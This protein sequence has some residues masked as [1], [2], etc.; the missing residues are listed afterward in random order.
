MGELTDRLVQ[1][2]SDFSPARVGE[3]VRGRS[4]A[5]LLDLFGAMMAASAPRYGA[6]HILRSFI[7]QQGGKP[8]AS[9]VGQR[10][11]TSTVNAALANGILGYYCDIEPHHTEAVLHPM[12]VVVP[13]ALA[14]GEF[15]RSSGGDLLAAV[16]LGVE[17]ACRIALALDPRALYSRGFHPTAVA[18]VF[19]ATAAA[20]WL[21]QLE[22]R[23]WQSAIGLAGLQAGGLLAWADDDTELSR[24]FNPGI[25]SRA[26]VTAATMAGLGLGGPWSVLEG[27]SDIFHAFSGVR[28]PNALLA[29]FGPHYAIEEL[30]TKLYACCAFLHPGLDALLATMKLEKLTIVDIASMDFHFSRTG[31]PIV[32][33]NR[34]RS[35]NAQYV[36]AVAA[37]KQTVMIDDILSDQRA[38]PQIAA[39][40]GRVRVIHDPD[41]DRDYPHVY[42]TRLIIRLHDG[43]E[44]SNRV[45]FPKG[46][47]RNPIAPEELIAKYRNLAV[48][49]FSKEAAGRLLDIVADVE[50]L[51]DVSELG[52][53]LRAP[54]RR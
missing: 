53:A 33:N 38:D 11:K 7:R 18:G 24:P 14:V 37:A 45:D 10:G 8:C 23:E 52:S 17:V 9:I 21:L 50:Q 30:A 39:L 41:L 51:A 22:A 2:L 35:H 36:L 16:V 25:A 3:T 34:L 5:H 27:K 13:A 47:P 12:A 4:K 20:G 46:H 26:G 44:F 1:D 6:A 29:E 54:G 28:R 48:H 31:A 15:K 32:D 49:G 40:Y 43:T 19:G 42:S